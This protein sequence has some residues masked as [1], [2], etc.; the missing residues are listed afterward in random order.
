MVLVL[1]RQDPNVQAESAFHCHC[2]EKMAS[3]VCRELTDVIVASHVYS[4]VAPTREI[5]YAKMAGLAAS[6]FTGNNQANVPMYDPPT[7]RCFDGLGGDGQLNYNSGAESTIE[8]L[9]AILEVERHAEARR[10]MNVQGLDA[11]DVIKDGIEY[12]Y[13]IFQTI[14]DSSPG[15]IAVVIDLDRQRFDLL[16]GDRLAEFLSS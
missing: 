13:R 2:F 14:E 9:Y 6:W 11:V 7:G 16:E 10:W 4:S 1:P 12:R 3:Q 5:K 15:R 8:A